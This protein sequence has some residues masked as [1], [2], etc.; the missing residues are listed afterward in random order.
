MKKLLA[1]F[2]CLTMLIGI[3]CVAPWAAN[4]AEANEPVSS[5]SVPDSV[6]V[7]QQESVTCTLAAATNMIRA[8]FYLSDND[9]W[10]NVTESS[11]HPVG[12]TN[13][14]GLNGEFTYSYNGNSAHLSMGTVSSMSV[15]SLKWLLDEHPEGVV[16]YSQSP[17]MHAVM[18]TDYVG[19][20]FYCVDSDRNDN[21]PL[22][23]IPLASTLILGRYGSQANI[24][25]HIQQYWVISNYSISPTN[26]RLDLGS[27]F[28]GLLIHQPSWIPVGLQTLNGTWA[29]FDTFNCAQYSTN[30]AVLVQE[31]NQSYA[32][33]LWRFQ[34][35]S[36][37][38]YTITSVVTGEQL[39]WSF[40]SSTTGKVNGNNGYSSTNNKWF[41]SQNGAGYT[42]SS[43]GKNNYTSDLQNTT[44]SM[45]IP[46][47]NAAFG[48]QIGMSASNKSDAQRFTIYKLDSTRDRLNY[49]ISASQT[50]LT[51]KNQK[52]EITI[53]G[54]INYAYRWRLHRIDPDGSHN[55]VCLGPGT[56]LTYHFIINDYMY[57]REGVYTFYAELKN[58]YGTEKGSVTT[59]CVKVTVR[60]SSAEG[61]YSYR[62]LDDGTASITAYNGTDT[63]IE[64]PS[65]IAG[66]Q[67]TKV[68]G[69]GESAKQ[70]VESVVIPEG[71]T[72]ISEA[73]ANC[74]ALKSA[75][76]PGSIEPGEYGGS[77]AAFCGCS[78]LENVTFGEGFSYIGYS[79]FSSCGISHI[80]IPDSVTMIAKYAFSGCQNLKEIVIPENTGLARC[81]IAQAHS[82][83]NVGD[84]FGAAYYD[85]YVETIYGVPGS[86]AE[87]YVQFANANL[88]TNIQFVDISTVPH[89]EVVEPGY[90]ATCTEDGLT[91]RI[92][93]SFCGQVL[94]EHEV[95]NAPGHDYQIVHGTPA[96]YTHTGL[97]DGV[98]CTHCGD[99]VV[100]QTVLAKLVSNYNPGDVTRAGRI[101]VN[102]VTAIQ[103]HISEIEPLSE[104]QM[105]LA[106]VNHDGD[107][108]IDDATLLQMY[109]AEYDVTIT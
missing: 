18:V 97:S 100:R 6:Y 38:E 26:R 25:A 56:G 66:R 61:D 32:R 46:N 70:T 105:Y 87:T 13:G 57:S 84:A 53:G 11:V 79:M 81:T 89:E 41:F 76:I 86:S 49:S 72:D 14:M 21:V 24:L 16:I 44:L 9:D 58:P 90:P 91:D 108:T 10:Q 85:C 102:G 107:V 15:A 77:S 28:Y 3:V 8:R 71:V 20:T 43:V 34:R 98:Q 73:F 30:P 52:A 50:L 95:I 63:D 33:T 68:A 65:T 74:T 54:T 103:R 101:T 94:Q 88:E 64:I 22:G 42:V 19:D 99:W 1:V 67:V 69:L 48:T 7:K 27:D 96:T 12:W 4:G 106:D 39:C 83:L 80:I 75:H 47:N 92:Y 59:K 29:D 23:R 93:C 45:N 2:L 35:G 17:E 109:L 55:E 60:T 62:V 36:N 5:A 31:N 37:N 104:E 40:N 82:A 51:Q 78:N